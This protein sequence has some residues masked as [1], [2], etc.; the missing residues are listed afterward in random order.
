MRLL[1]CFKIVPD[2][3]A[4]GSKDWEVSDSL[5]VDLSYVRPVWNCFDESALE[6]LLKLSDSSEGFNV[7]VNLWALTIG[8]KS[9][10]AYL[11][12]LYALGYEKAVRVESEE[13]L[14]FRPQWTAGVIA[15]YVK[16]FSEIDGI[17]MGSVSSDG[18]NAIT[19]LLTAEALGWPCITQVT[20]MEP[21]DERHIQ[22]TSMQDDGKVTRTVALPCV[23]VIGNASSSY[24][25][26]PTL[27]DRMKKGKK[28]VE[29]WTAE[30][31]GC[32][33]EDSQE[34]LTLE[35]LFVKNQERPGIRIQGK[36]AREKAEKLYHDYLKER[37]DAL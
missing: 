15:A 30:Q 12:T 16:K 9:A 24:L 2:M 7:L 3:E 25:R 21:V 8:G 23:F 5:F 34:G 32:L 6:M 18:N 13:D 29:Y 1:G 22:V 19:P 37:L 26:V 20:K 36:D 28:P 35:K 4:L 33:T 14:R 17:V 31:L 10:D 11:K 27:K